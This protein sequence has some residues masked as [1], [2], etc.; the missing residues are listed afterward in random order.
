MCA[1]VGLSTIGFFDRAP[2]LDQFELT[3]RRLDTC[4]IQN[5]N[6]LNAIFYS[7][8]RSI[9]LMHGLIVNLGRGENKR[10]FRVLFSYSEN[11]M[12][13]SGIV[14]GQI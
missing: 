2:P 9:W 7:G 13:L 12:V 14:W 3:R 8:P 6:I 10:P 11:R 5:T 4:R 1:L